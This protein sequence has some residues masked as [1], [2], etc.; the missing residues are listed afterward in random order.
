MT[1]GKCP[2]AGSEVEDHL[3]SP[4]LIKEA[5]NGGTFRI[6]ALKF[7]NPILNFG[8]GNSERQKASVRDIDDGV[9]AEKNSRFKIIGCLVSRSSKRDDPVPRRLVHQA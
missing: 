4:G 9:S 2:I 8:L 3:A 6:L 5:T 1:M 7:L